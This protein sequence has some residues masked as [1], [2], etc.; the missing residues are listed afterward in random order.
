MTDAFVE[1]LD[2]SLY[3]ILLT[4]FSQDILNFPLKPR[5]KNTLPDKCSTFISFFY[6]NIKKV[7]IFPPTVT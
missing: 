4:L 6:H 2:R 5:R 1:R 3:N 7:H